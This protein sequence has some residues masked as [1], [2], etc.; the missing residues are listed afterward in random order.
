MDVEGKQSG[1]EKDLDEVLQTTQVYENVSKGLFAKPKNLRKAFG[2]E[3]MEAICTQILTRGEL[4]VSDKERAKRY[5]ELFHEVATT[6]VEKCVN[7]E[8]GRP[9]PAGVIE[10]AM[11]DTLHFTPAINRAAKQQAL[12]VIK[13][14][15]ASEV[16][17]IARD[18]FTKKP[19]AN[20]WIALCYTFNNLLYFPAL[21]SL[22]AVA[23][24]VL[25]QSKTLFTAG[26]SGGS[27]GGASGA[28]ELQPHR[29]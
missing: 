22:S 15:E 6:I 25:S 20:A 21:S 17:P 2:T 13:Q 11:R 12:V 7:P 8:S 29:A 19:F 10:R 16:L 14:L 27:T 9:Y 28:D 24:Q 23:Y 3:D 18:A 5:D 1:V 26:G 4:Q